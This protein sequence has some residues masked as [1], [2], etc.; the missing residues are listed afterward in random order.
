[1]RQYLKI[2]GHDELRRDAESMGIVNTDREALHKYREEREFK[3]QLAKV[4]IEHEQIKNEL[5]EIKQLLL[6]LTKQR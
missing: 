4:V 6:L 2:V 1:M 3:R 5:G